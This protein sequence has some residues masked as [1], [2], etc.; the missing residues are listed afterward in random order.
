MSSVRELG[1][2]EIAVHPQDI[3][4][5]MAALDVLIKKGESNG[6]PMSAEK[7]TLRRLKVAIKESR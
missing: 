1:D 7:L 6:K 5:A 3:Y 4:T 2:N